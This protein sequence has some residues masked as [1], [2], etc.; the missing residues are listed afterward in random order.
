MDMEFLLTLQSR[1][2]ALPD[3]KTAAAM[4]LTQCQ[5]HVKQRQSAKDEEDAI[6]HKEGAAAILIADVR[7]APNVAQVDGETDDG[8]QKLSLLAPSL[9]M[10][11]CHGNDQ[12]AL[13]AEKKG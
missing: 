6:G 4:E 2:D 13:Q 5:F 9:P 11:L 8:Q 10:T 7:K 1:T 12:N 3:A